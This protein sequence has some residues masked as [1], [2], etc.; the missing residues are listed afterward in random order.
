MSLSPSIRKLLQEIP[1]SIL[2]HQIS[3]EK[4]IEKVTFLP[5]L[6]VKLLQNPQQIEL[7]NRVVEEFAFVQFLQVMPKDCDFAFCV[8]GIVLDVRLV[9]G[10]ATG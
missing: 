6:L 5:P 7:D 8:W 10:L 3:P 1:S 9:V 4:R 2:L